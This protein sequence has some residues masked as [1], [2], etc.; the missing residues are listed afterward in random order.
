MSTSWSGMARGQGT[1]RRSWKSRRTMGDASGSDD[2]KGDSLVV[3]VSG[4][5][6]WHGGV[7]V[8]CNGQRGGEVVWN[9]KGGGECPYQK[10]GENDS[11]RKGGKNELARPDSSY[12]A[13][14]SSS[15]ASSRRE[16][17]I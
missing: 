15:T 9:G 14:F 11:K 7:E 13:K 12:S 6:M 3:G 1:H 5:T 2:G 4:L 16:P 10:R 8:E 17:V